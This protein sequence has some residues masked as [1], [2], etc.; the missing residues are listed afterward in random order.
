MALAG[1][2]PYRPLRCEE[3]LWKWSDK[4]TDQMAHKHT[5]LHTLNSLLGGIS[6]H[7]LTVNHTLTFLTRK[8]ANTFSHTVSHHFGPGLV[9]QWVETLFYR[10]TDSSLEKMGEFWLFQTVYNIMQEDLSQHC[11][12]FSKSTSG[13]TWFNHV[14]ETNCSIK[15]KLIPAGTV[16]SRAGRVKPTVVLKEAFLK[17]FCSTFY[18][19]VQRLKKER[20]LT[21]NGLYPAGA[22]GGTAPRGPAAGGSTGR[23]EEKMPK[24]FRFKP[25]IR[26]ACCCFRRREAGFRLPERYIRI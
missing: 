3:W 7:K 17:S 18:G 21:K 15:S 9:R 22:T 16:H 12:V 19:C 25:G 26:L 20:I 14:L 1:G 4:Q 10:Q 11:V 23:P 13:A 5:Y 8:H 6:G 2:T 24:A